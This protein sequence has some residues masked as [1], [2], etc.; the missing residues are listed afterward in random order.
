MAKPEWGTKCTCQEC[1]AKFYDMRRAE[2]I[3]PKCEAAY[4]VAPPKPKRAQSE[5]KVPEEAKA[6]AAPVAASSDDQASNAEDGAGD[7]DGL[8][9]IELGVEEEDVE[10]DDENMIEDTSDLGDDDDDVAEVVQKPGATDE[11]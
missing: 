4:H 10:D 7:A 3:C 5:T 9:D 1:G 6:P 11:T 8:G 2:V